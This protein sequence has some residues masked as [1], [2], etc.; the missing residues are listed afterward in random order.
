LCHVALDDQTGTAYAI[1]N[2]TAWR[3]DGSTSRRARAT[4]VKKFQDF[5]Y[6]LEEIVIPAVR[7]R[8]VFFPCAQT[9]F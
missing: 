5:F 6:S 3:G 7:D 8:C 1:R 4:G 9:S 2:T